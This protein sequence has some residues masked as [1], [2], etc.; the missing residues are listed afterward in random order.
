MC[1]R[2]HHEVYGPKASAVLALH[3]LVRHRKDSR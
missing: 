1:P 3:R 2:C